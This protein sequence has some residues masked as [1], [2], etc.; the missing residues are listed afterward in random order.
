M[1]T[2]QKTILKDEDRSF[3]YSIRTYRICA[4]L[5][6]Y[7]HAFRCACSPYNIVPPVLRQVDSSETHPSTRTMHQDF[8]GPGSPAFLHKRTVGCVIWDPQGG[9]LKEGQLVWETMYLY[10]KAVG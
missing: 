7:F 9:A 4:H 8:V 10:V 3:L 1:H 6:N 2:S 5:F